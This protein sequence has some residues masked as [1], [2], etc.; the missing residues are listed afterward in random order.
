MGLRMP[1]RAE[2]MIRACLLSRLSN[3]QNI[4][5]GDVQGKITRVESTP[6]TEYLSHSRI[7]KI[8][9]IA[10]AHIYTVK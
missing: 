5:F 2:L 8:I 10:S 1:Y 4:D 9:S 7:F 6:R 3:P